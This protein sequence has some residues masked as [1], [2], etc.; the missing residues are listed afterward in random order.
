MK[1][2]RTQEIIDLIR[3]KFVMAKI[4]PKKIENASVL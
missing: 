3:G 2:A 1:Y 4:I